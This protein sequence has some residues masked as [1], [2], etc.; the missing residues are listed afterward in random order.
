MEE[1]QVH[2]YLSLLCLV[3]EVQAHYYLYFLVVKG[4]VVVENCQI[5]YFYLL[6]KVGV[7][8]L[9][10]YFLQELVIC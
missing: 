2:Y 7:G 10:W 1:V 8:V 6:V 5:S 4:E 3:A 9:S